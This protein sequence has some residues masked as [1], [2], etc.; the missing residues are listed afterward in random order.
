MWTGLLLA[1]GLAGDLCPQPDRA[2][3]AE[4]V[5]TRWGEERGAGLGREL[6]TLD[7]LDGDGLREVVLTRS[8]GEC[9]ELLVL[10]GADLEPV[11]RRSEEEL[12]AG[13]APARLCLVDDRDGDGLRDLLLGGAPAVRVRSHASWSRSRGVR[14]V[15]R[16][17]ATGERIGGVELAEGPL[18]ALASLA[19]QDGDG[20]P[21]LALGLREHAS[22]A[23]ASPRPGAWA[24]AVAILSGSLL[25]AR[26]DGTRAAEVPP[27]PAA[28]ARALAPR[29]PRWI[30]QAGA[31]VVALGDLDRDGVKD[32]ACGDPSCTVA[33]ARVGAVSAF[34]GRTG[35]LLW[36][37]SGSGASGERALGSALA[38][39][40][41][42]DGDGVPDLA[43]SSKRGG[44]GALRLFSAVDGRPLASLSDGPDERLLG[45]RPIS[46]LGHLDGDG[47]PEL[48]VAR[49]LPRDERASWSGD[50]HE[51][52]AR[53]DVLA[54]RDL[55]VL[56]TLRGRA[57]RRVDD[58]A[59][60]VAWIVS[61]DPGAGREGREGEGALRLYRI[62]LR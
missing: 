6:A 28:R 55:A 47:T 60:D 21:E 32:L 24:E 17:A 18:E 20:L 38:S 35:A 13:A 16:S 44:R 23:Q 41:D 25:P 31:S 30:L 46:P 27:R 43:A 39:I 50:P 5:A 34:S 58:G 22:A 1:L 49:A 4:L 3:F 61:A 54:G 19:D 26:L 62:A 51:R 40:G 14:L 52:Q 45:P 56:A 11:W 7:D 59:A 48:A 9:T 53:L 33:G 15:L 10:R 37:V 57:A 8:C 12:S 42:H 36:S 2:L 29:D